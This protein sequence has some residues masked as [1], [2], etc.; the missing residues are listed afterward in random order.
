MKKIVILGTGGNCIDILE[1]L[2]DI[3]R[4]R[5]KTVYECLGFLDDDP[6]KWGFTFQGMKVLGPLNKSTEFYDC[7]FVF[8][9]GSV[10]NFWKRDDILAKTGVENQRLE[11]IIHPTAYISKS[12]T[13]G[14][15]SI[16]FQNTVIAS[17][18]TIGTC[19]Y[20]LP[21]TT[22]SHN[23]TIGDFTCVTGNV[24]ISGNVQI[25]KKCYIGANSSI[26]DGVSI[27]E[28]SLV[29]MGSVV[30]KDVSENCVAVG[31]PAR[32]L[33]NVKSDTTERR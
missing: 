31:N 32:L 18:V 16:I 14:Q 7:F 5:G 12:A 9:I 27:G 21:N 13:V 1:T 22:I 8:G 33:R 30:L 2:L 19:V 29:G 26:K 15:G 4:A 28:S 11:T 20:L 24:C 17:S 6:G 23:S 3:N 25:G 10:S